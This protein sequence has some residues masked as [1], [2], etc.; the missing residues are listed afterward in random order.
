MRAIALATLT[1]MLT[2]MGPPCARQAAASDE[3][4]FRI[5]DRV[6]SNEIEEVTTLIVDGKTIRSFHLDADDH[7]IAIDVTV[8]AA[9]SH[10]FGLCG[11]ILVRTR[12]GATLRRAFDISGLLH[13]VSGR[14]F[15]AVAS[16]AYTHF[17]LVD[18]TKSPDRPPARIEPLPGHACVP[19][20]S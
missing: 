3:Q 19:A 12:E 2:L 1:L 18:T 17:Y 5:H 9:E 13:D 4:T 15:E 7:E 11:H 14:D 6:A 8:P 16:D 10:E 20:V